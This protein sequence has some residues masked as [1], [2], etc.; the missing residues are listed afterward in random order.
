MKSMRLAQRE[1]C[2]PPSGARNT[3]A[4]GGITLRLIAGAVLVGVVGTAIFVPPSHRLD[5]GMPSVVF[6][7]QALEQRA[8]QTDGVLR[9][10]LFQLLASRSVVNIGQKSGGL[11]RPPGQLV[12]KSGSPHR[13]QDARRGLKTSKGPS[14]A[15]PGGEILAAPVR[16]AVVEG[17]EGE[18]D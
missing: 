10:Q 6:W 12:T 2:N 7:R 8:F 5:R 1:W 14:G 11:G 17:V 3:V 13:Q 4:T 9:C 18:N 16:E 15:G